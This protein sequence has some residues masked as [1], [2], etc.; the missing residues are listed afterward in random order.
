[1]LTRRPFGP[2]G[3]AVNPIGFGAWAIG[4]SWGKVAEDDARAAL[5]AARDSGCDTAF[6]LRRVLLDKAVSAVIPGATSAAQARANAAAALPQ[7]SAETM[8]ALRGICDRLVAPH[9][10]RRW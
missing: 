2:A 9:V 8:A 6:A 5:H 4:G 7:L 3:R 10:H 1:M